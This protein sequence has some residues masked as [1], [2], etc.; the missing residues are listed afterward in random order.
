MDGNS[1]CVV[2]KVVLGWSN[3]KDKGIVAL[4]KIFGI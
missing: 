2:V 3:F 1:R 4:Y